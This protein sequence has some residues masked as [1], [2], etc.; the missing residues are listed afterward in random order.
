VC[1]VWRSLRTWCAAMA[2]LALAVVPLEPW[3]VP[4]PLAGLAHHPRAWWVA[5]TPVCLPGGVL[6]LNVFDRYTSIEVHVP[7]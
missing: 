7:W 4:S 1:G 5:N 6:C 2:L 3:L